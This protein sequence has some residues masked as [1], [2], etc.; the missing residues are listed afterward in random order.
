MNLQKIF[1]Y[2]VEKLKRLKGSLA[3]VRRR[4]NPFI[5]L[6]KFSIRF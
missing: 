6:I 5:M 2:W 4:S 1:M 3:E